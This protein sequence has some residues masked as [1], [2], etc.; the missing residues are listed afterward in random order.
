MMNGIQARAEGWREPPYE[1]GLEIVF[2]FLALAA[3]LAGAVLFVARRNEDRA[4]DALLVRPAA[5]FGVAAIGAGGHQLRH[6]VGIDLQ[7][8][9]HGA[10]RTGCPRWRQLLEPFVQGSQRQRAEVQVRQF[11]LHLPQT[12]A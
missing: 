9:R 3:G 8:G 5:P 1:E 11:L 7:D 4:F 12:Q 10:G 2:W 6:P